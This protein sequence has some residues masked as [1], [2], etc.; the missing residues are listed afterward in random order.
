MSQLKTW[1]LED[2][3]AAINAIPVDD[4]LAAKFETYAN[5]LL[6]ALRHGKIAAAQVIWQKISTERPKLK[7]KIKNSRDVVGGGRNA[8]KLAVQEILPLWR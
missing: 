6:F 5:A 3:E 7:N 8:F 4:L 1:I 2:N